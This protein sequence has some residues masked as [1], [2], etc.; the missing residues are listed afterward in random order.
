MGQSSVNL[1]CASLAILFGFIFIFGLIQNAFPRQKWA[2]NGDKL[3]QR[4]VLRSLNLGTHAKPLPKEIR[5]SR[6]NVWQNLDENEVKDIAQWLLARKDLNL[7]D[8]EVAGPW[9]NTM[10]V[11]PVAFLEHN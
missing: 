2:A 7:T 4:L 6:K 8:P 5:A 10:C 9:S 11:K 3:Y 1:R